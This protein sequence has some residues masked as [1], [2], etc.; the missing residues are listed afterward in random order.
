MM[1]SWWMRQVKRCSQKKM[2]QF[3][4]EFSGKLRARKPN[5]A[6]TKLANITCVHYFLLFLRVSTC[7]VNFVHYPL[8]SIYFTSSL[9][10]PTSLFSSFC[11]TRYQYLCRRHDHNPVSVPPFGS[12]LPLPLLQK[13]LHSIRRGGASSFVR[14]SSVGA[15]MEPLFGPECCCSAWGGTPS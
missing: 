4:S 12:P 2:S 3:F 15:E 10:A 6:Q 1:P 13:I 5:K 8:S 14:R 7:G 11:Q 9:F